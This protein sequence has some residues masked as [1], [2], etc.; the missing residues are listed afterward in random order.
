MPY[1]LLHSR[2]PKTAEAE[3]RTIT[4]LRRTPSGLPPGSYSFLEMFCDE[5]KCDCR[6]VFLYVV[7]SRGVDPEAVIAWGWES[8][9]FYAKWLH[10]DDPLVLDELQGPAL[11]LASPQSDLSSPIL[12]LAR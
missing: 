2:F 10:D 3:T 7:S 8:R 12:E 9:G 6:R 5:P 1:A 11:N 4:V